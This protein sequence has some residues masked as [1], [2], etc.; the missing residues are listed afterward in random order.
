M[1]E[2]RLRDLSLTV[3]HA[4]T[5]GYTA[6]SPGGADA[7]LPVPEAGAVDPAREHGEAVLALG[8]VGDGDGRFVRASQELDQTGWSRAHCR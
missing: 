8:V 5:P 3:C 7:A 1:R 2:A 6:E 4:W